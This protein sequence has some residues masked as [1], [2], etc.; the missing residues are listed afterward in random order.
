MDYAGPTPSRAMHAS[1][2]IVASPG[3]PPTHHHDA[4]HLWWHSTSIV[5]AAG[6]TAAMVAQENGKTVLPAVER[7]YVGMLVAPLKWLTTSTMKTV[8]VA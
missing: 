8:G 6:Q 5:N 4:H 1:T 2:S 3:R 7:T